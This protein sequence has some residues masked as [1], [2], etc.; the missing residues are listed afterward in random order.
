MEQ[1]RTLDAHYNKN[2]IKI[3]HFI[4]IRLNEM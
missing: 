1:E 3:L 2:V 4:S